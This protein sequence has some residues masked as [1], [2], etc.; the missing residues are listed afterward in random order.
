MIL[1]PREIQ[2]ERKDIC[3]SCEDAVKNVVGILTCKHC[4]CFIDAAVKWK[5][6]YCPL[7]KWWKVE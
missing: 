7:Q 4:G 6:G 1:A 2:K 5:G 3:L